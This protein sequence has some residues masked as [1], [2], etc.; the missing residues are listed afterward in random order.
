MNIGVSTACFYPLETEE[1]L[2]EIGQMGVKTTEIFFNSE[3]EKKNAF[4]DMLE[5]IKDGYGLSVK[6]IHPTM[7]LSENFIFF[8]DYPR[9][10]TEGL[11]SYARY[12][13][14]AARLGA[15]FIIM[16][17]GKAHSRM[18]D[19]E[20]CER[21]MHI[22]NVTLKNGVTVLQENVARHRSGDIESLRAMVDILGPDAEFC[23]DIKQ[24]VRCG[25]DPFLL[26][27]EFSDNIRHYHISD[28]SLASDCMLPGKG[29]FDFKTLF[30]KNQNRSDLS[31]M[32]EVYNN[33]YKNPS[34]IA[35]SFAN[36]VEI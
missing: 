3:Y 35:E 5:D 28:H 31:Y 23:M 24:A 10:F 16:H 36:I 4:I 7:S 1:A 11:D 29:K 20:Y 21:Y 15:K 12:S 33:S 14:I 18:E 8:S 9:R 27:D 26:I 17:G 34:E 32:I 30:S 13:E 25:Y 19:E 2:R 6:A 22:K